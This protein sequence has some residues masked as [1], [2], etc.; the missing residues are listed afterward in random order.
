[1]FN[2]KD[3]EIL[4]RVVQP[5]AQREFHRQFHDAT[6]QAKAGWPSPS[7]LPNF[8]EEDWLS[9]AKCKPNL[10][11]HGQ[12]K[13]LLRLTAEVDAIDA[14]TL[15]NQFARTNLPNGGGQTRSTRGAGL[16]SHSVPNR[17][18]ERCTV[19]ISLPVWIGMQF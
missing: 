18:A 9:S 8:I 15:D 13:L 11:G 4:D 16:V 5:A 2:M 3:A 6:T 19:S 7:S 1:M 14:V 10:I 12:T 17:S